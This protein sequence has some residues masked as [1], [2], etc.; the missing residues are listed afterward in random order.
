MLSRDRLSY[1][2][3]ALSRQKLRG[4]M[5][6][7]AIS[8]SVASILVLT[9]LG[10][11]AKNFVENEFAFLGKD[12]LILLPGKKETTGGMPPI[13]GATA[14]DL[15]LAD[16]QY[17]QRQIPKMIAVPLVVGTA[18]ASYQARLRQTI[19]LGTTSDFLITHHLQLIMGSQLPEHA[20]DRAQ[21]LALIGSDLAEELYPQQAPVGQWLRL[22]NRRF[23]IIG[24]FESNS[25]NMGLRLN[26]AVLIP[27]ATAQDLFNSPGLFRLFIQAA[28]GQSL[29]ELQDRVSLLIRE[30]H[31]GKDDVT[32]LQPDA[33][34]ATFGE[35]LV[36]LTLAVAGIGTISLVVAGIMMMNIMLISTHQRSPEIGLLKALGADQQSIRAL[37]LTEAL[38]LSLAGASLGQGAGFITVQLL[39]WTYP[40]F[41]L[42]VPFWAALAAFISA[43]LF[44]L[45]FA[46]LPASQAARKDPVDCL[47]GAT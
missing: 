16:M 5:L 41:P 46:L 20:I 1:A 39:V 24:V 25:S 42:A 33:L 21:S 18:E 31:Q 47:K 11:G 40:A 14:R 43:P 12:L 29:D 34:L 27:V 38:L 28:E 13:T 15:T 6:L 8:L 32:I 36:T 10:Q 3:I 22:D 19:T 9:A 37:F 26:E 35:I 30:R 45:L 7:L 17:V 2:L 23:R 44:G 4:S